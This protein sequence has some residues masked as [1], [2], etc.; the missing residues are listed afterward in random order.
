MG[1]KFPP[2]PVG[3]DG[4]SSP[5]LEEL[6][7]ELDDLHSTVS[8]LSWLPRSRLR[9]LS[10]SLFSEEYG[11]PDSIY[12]SACADSLIKLYGGTLEEVIFSNAW[13]LD[14]PFA[15]DFDRN[16][17]GVFR[18]TDLVLGTDRGLARER[19]DPLPTLYD[20]LQTVSVGM[21][22]GLYLT[23]VRIE[24]NHADNTD[25]S[26]DAR[27]ESLL[28]HRKA[29]TQLRILIISP[30]RPKDI[31]DMSRQ[32]TEPDPSKEE[33]LAWKISRYVPPS[34]RYISI[35]QYAF[36]VDRSEGS[37]DF[38]LVSWSYATGGFDLRL[39]WDVHKWATRDDLDFIDPLS[40]LNQERHGVEVPST[41]DYTH[42]L[43]W[44]FLVARRVD[45]VTT[46]PE[47]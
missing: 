6:T 31:K 29:F 23:R 42:L 19:P 32:G 30:K 10:I 33:T 25:D 28:D 41:P 3:Y 4:T 39:K 9:R 45:G 37:S 22:L 38:A 12:A 7:T 24:S 40:R 1:F 13:R 17:G 20:Y 11:F 16:W 47:T 8:I 35:G 21:E 26:G 18:I 36:W 27:L 15:Y 5:A 46:D 34:L 14:P 44:N 2:A 43:R